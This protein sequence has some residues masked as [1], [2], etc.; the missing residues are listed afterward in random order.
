VLHLSLLLLNTQA[1]YLLILLYLEVHAVF[2]LRIVCSRSNKS[3]RLED[4]FCIC[5][6]LLSFLLKINDFLINILLLAIMLQQF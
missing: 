1:H 5:G 3:S 2:L 4:F 6:G